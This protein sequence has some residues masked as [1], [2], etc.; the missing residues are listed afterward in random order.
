M[1]WTVRTERPVFSAIRD[2]APRHQ[3]GFMLTVSAQRIAGLLAGT[4]RLHLV[5]P[6][7]TDPA[8]WYDMDWTDIYTRNTYRI[9]DTVD[10]ANPDSIPVNTLWNVIDTWAT[11]PEPKSL[12]P[13]GQVCGRD[14]IGLLKKRPVRTTPELVTLIGK[15]SNHLEE[16]QAGLKERGD[17]LNEY[18][19]PE[20]DPWQRLV[21]PAIKQLGPAE[22]ARAA[23]VNRRTVERLVQGTPPRPDTRQRVIEAVRTL[24]G[25]PTGP[26]LDETLAA[27]LEAA[28][29]PKCFEC[30]APLLKR[31]RDTRYCN[32]TCRVRHR[33]REGTETIMRFLP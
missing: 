12:D 7:E 27:F 17:I 16:A 26:G 3:Y 13:D 32:S 29:E 18:P 25:I 1:R 9:T 6:F 20:R 15:E 8:Y 22:V 33:R 21:I 28:E 11:N 10:P 19:D 4:D 31:R 2:D 30:G 14:T 23:G 5:A 24:A